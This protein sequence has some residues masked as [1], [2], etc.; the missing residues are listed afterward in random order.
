LPPEAPGFVW[1]AWLVSTSF[2]SGVIAVTR[3]C[4]SETTPDDVL[5]FVDFETLLDIESAIVGTLLWLAAANS[6]AR[7][8]G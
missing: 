3:V 5:E 2:L 4:L 7:V 8:F 6:V 1:I